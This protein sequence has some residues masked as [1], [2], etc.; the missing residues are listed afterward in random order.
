L[1]QGSLCPD[2]VRRHA[3]PCPSPGPGNGDHVQDLPPGEAGTPRP[4]PQSLR[5]RSTSRREAIR[6]PCPRPE[7]HAPILPSLELHLT[8]NAPQRHAL[9]ADPAGS[10]PERVNRGVGQASL[11]PAQVY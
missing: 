3:A 5:L 1:S 4:T 2:P 7:L 9:G 8:A 11:L 10:L 6:L